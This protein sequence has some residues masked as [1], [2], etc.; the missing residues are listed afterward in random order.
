MNAAAKL[1]SWVQLVAVVDRC[2][3]DLWVVLGLVQDHSDTVAH[4][5]VDL[6]VQEYLKGIHLAERVKYDEVM[7]RLGHQWELDD[8]TLLYLLMQKLRW[9]AYR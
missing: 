2:E 3:P 5:E 4:A 7:S 9:I 8:G 1:S 6:R